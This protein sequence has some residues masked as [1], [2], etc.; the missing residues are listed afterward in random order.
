MKWLLLTICLLIIVVFCW[1]CSK[2]NVQSEMSWVHRSGAPY[3]IAL[4]NNKSSITVMAVVDFAC[5]HCHDEWPVLEK[6]SRSRKAHVVLI[7]VGILSPSSKALGS[8]ALAN[9][10]LLNKL[11]SS[12]MAWRPQN[13]RAWV[14]KQSELNPR[15]MTKTIKQM[16]ENT[17]WFHRQGFTG[18]PLLFVGKRDA[19]NPSSRFLGET[20]YP[21]LMHAIQQENA[22]DQ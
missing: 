4:D 21:T 10:N 11:M 6:I 2:S 19:L 7:P 8:I 3:G 20:G 22:N 12:D 17:M 13:F 1:V 14:Q 18:V 15:L 5:P 9:P 16:Q